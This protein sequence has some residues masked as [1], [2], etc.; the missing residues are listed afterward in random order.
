[1][2]QDK[3]IPWV[4]DLKKELKHYHVSYQPMRGERVKVK[5]S[6]SHKMG[7]PEFNQ[8]V[9]LE[10]GKLGHKGGMISG[11]QE[12]TQKSSTGIG[13]PIM[14]SETKGKKSMEKKKKIKPK[15]FVQP[16]PND[17][18]KRLGMLGAK[19]QL[20]RPRGS[21]KQFVE[22][23]EGKKEVTKAEQKI[24]GG[25]AD[26]SEAKEF[27]AEELR[28]GIEIEMEH[29]NDPDKAK[30]IAMDHLKEI[31]D[32]YT[33]LKA[34]EEKANKDGIEKSTS[35]H[36]LGH[37]NE[38]EKKALQTGWK[39]K[40][41]KHYYKHAHEDLHHGVGQDLHHDTQWIK[42]GERKASAMLNQ[43]YERRDVEDEAK[44][45]MKHHFKNKTSTAKNWA[46]HFRHL[47]ATQHTDGLD[48]PKSDSYVKKAKTAEWTPKHP[49]AFGSARREHKIGQ[50]VG[51][52]DDTGKFREGSVTDIRG[53][54]LHI[55]DAEGNVH[56]VLKEDLHLP[57]KKIDCAHIELMHKSIQDDWLLR[58]G[59]EFKDM[60]KSA[61][62]LFK[63]IQLP[64]AAIRQYVFKVGD[65][66]VV[67]KTLG[68]LIDIKCHSTIE[69]PQ[70]HQK[71]A[72]ALFY[73]LQMYY[74]K[75]P[76]LGIEK[77]SGPTSMGIFKA[78]L[79][80]GRALY[81]GQYAKP[82]QE[83]L[84][85]QLNR[86]RKVT[87]GRKRRPQMGTRKPKSLQEFREGRV[88]ARLMGQQEEKKNVGKS[89]TP[90]G[91]EFFKKTIK[92]L[93]EKTKKSAITPSKPTPEKASID[94]PKASGLK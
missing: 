85:G 21:Y 34:M 26:H 74:H 19:M 46:K 92:K 50:M 5:I 30:E 35:K 3:I 68:R 40:H 49:E 7:S 6:T 28:Y 12:I 8:Y 16:S 79:E 59:D 1:M 69:S 11:C 53:E 9:H 87:L 65:C 61:G 42:G 4:P 14:L 22:S 52:K 37:Y 57:I 56:R 10:A 72:K 60:A 25:L 89:L 71:L 39:P 48:D 93:R 47:D 76:A 82:W 32:Y 24:E 51:F 20:E 94:T 67:H 88:S 73:K 31:P 18:L 66:A 64:S 81:G 38:D 45:G 86:R 27:N 23:T 55:R 62:I 84:A 43:G 78:E 36:S 83:G 17:P 15:R 91:K 29:T 58:L 63:T 77:Y 80:K 33:R 44:E 2:K 70:S 90:F 13:A 41:E 54:K 75:N